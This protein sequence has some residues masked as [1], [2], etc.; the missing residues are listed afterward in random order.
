MSAYVIVNVDTTDPV[1]YEEYKAM[2]QDAVARFGGRYLV[3][4]GRMKVVEGDWRPTRIVVLE[5]ESFET[6]TAWWESEL[7]ATAKALRQSLSST[8]MVIV[9]GYGG[10]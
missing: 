6:A 1:K 5:F 4:G 10:G 7:Y 9:D 8:D 2:A 3:R